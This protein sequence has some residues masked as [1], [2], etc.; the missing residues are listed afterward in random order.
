MYL[1]PARWS[2]HARRGAPEKSADGGEA[3]KLG[4]LVASICF[5]PVAFG[6]AVQQPKGT[7][8][9]PG[10]IQ[11]P[12][13]PWQ[14]PGDIQIPRGIQA[15]HQESSKC[16]QRT[17]V[18]SDALFEFNKDQLNPDAEQT[19]KVLGPMLQQAANHPVTIQ[20]YTDSIGTDAYNQGLSERRARSV[21]QWLVSNNFLKA[22][23]AQV[24]GFG[25]KNPVAP[26]SNSDGSDNPLGRQKNRR[27]EI[28]IDTC[29]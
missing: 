29:H 6:Q 25:K 2:T 22:S 19:L 10:Q 1:L 9:T 8:Q 18:G 16:T 26:N 17:V 23:A 27:V 7:W 15:I 24:Q 20:G 13:G 12:K 3:M 4:I 21:E 14:T 11:Q 28:V 5:A